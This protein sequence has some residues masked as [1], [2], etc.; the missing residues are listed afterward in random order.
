M[1]GPR[2]KRQS[3]CFCCAVLLVTALPAV[4]S[5][6]ALFL[7]TWV[8]LQQTVPNASALCRWRN[9]VW[10][11]GGLHPWRTL[12]K[13]PCPRFEHALDVDLLNTSTVLCCTAIRRELTTAVK[14]KVPHFVLHF[15]FAD[16]TSTSVCSA[17]A[18]KM[19]VIRCVVVPSVIAT[20]S[21]SGQGGSFIRRA[22]SGLM[23]QPTYIRLQ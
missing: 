15:L 12:T 14:I 11:G 1:T 10:G 18:V 17:A 20:T 7:T 8:R 22:R 13:R 21:R 19:R 23:T 3:G 9:V 16:A 5:C 6:P 4:D 2:G